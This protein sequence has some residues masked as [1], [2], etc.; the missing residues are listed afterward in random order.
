MER[1]SSHQPLINAKLSKRIVAFMIDTLLIYFLLY[2]FRK[3]FL[4]SPEIEI[5]TQ[6]K[7]SIMNG[8]FLSF[9][10]ILL[11]GQT[12]GKRIMKI[13]LLGINDQKL[14]LM[15]LLNREIF[16]KVF[17][18]KIN[19]WIL[20]I[21]F[22]TGSLDTIL[23][24]VV[25]HPMYLILWYVISLPWVMFLSFTMLVNSKEHQS[26]HDIISGTKVIEKEYEKKQKK[27]GLIG[28]L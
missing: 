6:I 2:L 18:E 10:S 14:D 16:G 25:D 7:N 27:A 9:Y 22:Y 26:L 12:I 20:L 5:E 24:N 4:S 17:M 15:S 1:T 28:R 3:A 19:L 13:E 21:L 23:V 8:L 11:R